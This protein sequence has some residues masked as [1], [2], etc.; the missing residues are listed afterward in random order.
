MMGDWRRTEEARMKLLAAILGTV[1]LAVASPAPA[2]DAAI[3]LAPG[4]AATVRLAPS[5]DTAAVQRGAARWTA[6]DLA[7]ARHLSGQPVPDAPVDTAEMLPNSMPAAPPVAPGEIRL[8]FHLIADQH[9]F[10]V[11]ENGYDRAVVYRARMTLDDQSRPTD[12]CLVIPRRRGYEHWP[13]RI[14]RLDLSGF[15]FAD[16]QEGDP[17]PCS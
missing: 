4:D 16:W 8:H 6:L 13:H 7:A 5:G 11:I 2:Q 15:A 17:I 9:A 1:L 3:S 10:L 12:V 14:D